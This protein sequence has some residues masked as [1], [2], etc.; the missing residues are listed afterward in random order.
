MTN[1]RWFRMYAEIKNDPKL[2]R[3]DHAGRWLWVV[4]LCLAS[5]S[6]ERGSL[7]LAEGLPYTIEEIAREADLDLVETEKHVNLMAKMGMLDEDGGTFK[8][9][10]WSK[11]QFTS[12]S[13]AERTRR[14]R[15]G[16]LGT[17]QERHRDVTVTSRERHGDSPYT[18]SDPDSDS[19]KDKKLESAERA[20]MSEL[21][22]VKGY[23]FEFERDL[24]FIRGLLVEFPGLD[25]LSEAKRWKTVK[26]DDPL[27][28]KSKPR[29]QFR[30]WCMKA[31]EFGRARHPPEQRADLLPN[32]PF[33]PAGEAQ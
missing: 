5:E 11:R 27:K 25:L 19:E 22:A 30:N 26:L 33:E 4:I 20:I 8:I 13:S 16:R 32:I 28:A 24:E 17:S 6:P 15:G 9:R 2:R 18:D 31:V 12:D 23:P 10:N 14:W 3:L 7:L 1:M 21:K 29:S